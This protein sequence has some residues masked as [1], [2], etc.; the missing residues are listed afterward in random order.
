MEFAEMPLASAVG[1]VERSETHH[2]QC[3]AERP[4]MG[5][6][7]LNPSYKNCMLIDKIFFLGYYYF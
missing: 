2:G 3:R 6:A 1:W 7:A 4:R 5:F